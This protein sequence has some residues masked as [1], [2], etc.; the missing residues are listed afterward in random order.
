MVKFVICAHLNLYQ[1]IK[2]N[3]TAFYVNV[4]DMKE[5]EEERGSDGRTDKSRKIDRNSLV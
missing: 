1:S 2:Y 4:S 5:K 3:Q